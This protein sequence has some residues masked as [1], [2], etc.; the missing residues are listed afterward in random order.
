[1]EKK[2]QI[3]IVVSALQAASLLWLCLQ[4]STVLPSLPALAHA[5]DAQQ[6]A[7]VEHRLS[8]YQ[9]LPVTI[10]ND[11]AIRVRCID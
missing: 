1:M 8:R 4:T 5:A 10:R 11:D 6:V 9:P 2:L 3:L 7:L